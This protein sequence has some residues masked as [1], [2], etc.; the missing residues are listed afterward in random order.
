M[1][2]LVGIYNMNG[3]SVDPHAL[4]KMADIQSHRGLDSQ[5]VRLF[6]LK[7]RE[8]IS[9]ESQGNHLL[10]DKFEGGLGFN[11]LSILDLSESGNQPMCN[12]DG[13]VFIAFNGEIYNAF[14]Y[15]S[16]LTAA[17]FS[18]NSK[19]DTEV[20][21]HLYELYGFVGMLERL[22]GMFAI[23][24]VDLNSQE[25]FLAR[26]RMGIK[27]LYWYE[28]NGTFIFASEVK[29]FLCHPGFKAELDID[30]ADE[31][32]VFRYCA[33]SGNLLKGVNQLEP[34]YWLRM[35]CNG[36][37]KHKYWTIPDRTCEKE[38]SFD[39]ALRMLDKEL[40]RSVKMRLLSD[41]KLGCQLS[42]GVDSS[43]I[44]I[45]ASKYSGAD[46]DAIS[47]I[48]EDPQFS[49]EEWIDDVCFLSN[50]HVHKYILDNNYF[51]SNLGKATWHMDQPLNHPNSLGIFYIAENAR[52]LVTVLLS[53]E[54]ADELFGGYERFYFAMLRYRL[55]PMLPV[56]SNLPRIGEKFK[57]VFG[58]SV[59]SVS[60][61]I[62]QTAFQSADNLISIRPEACLDRVF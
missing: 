6:S 54:G 10:Y 34:G 61:F 49:E 19:T 45:F 57:R 37:N 3:T 39:S 16:A 22:N 55:K 62:T 5:G 14:Q 59:D 53:G 24:I 23:C 52:S 12:K 50:I 32:F 30:R 33:G 4:C 48:F 40:H 47:I 43:L 41:V 29:S 1:C 2:G 21:L 15:L 11:R 51:F 31:Y 60:W 38:I 17:G 13:S 27:P 42:G 26:D 46:L 8:S 36:W 7:E 44:N 9:Y 35:N 18:F 28:N 58:D 25:L 56:L 20:V